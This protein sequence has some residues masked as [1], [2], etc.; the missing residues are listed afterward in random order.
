VL[1]KRGGGG[2]GRGVWGKA[3]CGGRRGENGGGVGREKN[4]MAETV[5]RHR[6]EK[7]KKRG[8]QKEKLLEG[9]GVPCWVSPGKKGEGGQIKG[10]VG[11]GVGNAKRKITC[12]NFLGSSKNC[13]GIPKQDAD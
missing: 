1:E 8:Y 5:L 9:H 10:S 7:R 13:L 6:R 12:H 11:N 3:G 4:R 2:G